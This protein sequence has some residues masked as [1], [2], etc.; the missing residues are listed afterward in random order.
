LKEVVEALEENSKSKIRQD[1]RIEI[2]DD[3]MALKNQGESSS[4]A[5]LD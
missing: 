3:E 1:Y 4:S 2:M 5:F